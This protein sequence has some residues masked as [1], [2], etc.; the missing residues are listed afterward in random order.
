MSLLQKISQYQQQVC[1][2]SEQVP[3]TGKGLKEI[4]SYLKNF[5]E[6]AARVE[7]YR[8][9][10]NDFS[11]LYE[12]ISKRRHIPAKILNDK[13]HNLL[14]FV[15]SVLTRGSTSVQDILRLGML[16]DAWSVSTVGVLKEDHVKSINAMT[17]R[18]I[19]ILRK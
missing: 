12:Y 14:D 7:N 4:F 3:L 18:A 10:Y 9:Y 15:N 5:L 17:K 11:S 16:W 2:L 19:E 8:W 6:A 1:D 13:Y